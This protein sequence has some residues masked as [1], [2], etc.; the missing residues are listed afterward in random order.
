MLF[1]K[2]QLFEKEQNLT[3]NQHKKQ[4][5]N[6]KNLWIAY[7]CFFFNIYFLVQDREAVIYAASYFLW[8]GLTV[9]G[10][11]KDSLSSAFQIWI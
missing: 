9:N 3:I 5:T 1:S 8:M 7:F 6:L 4:A 10:L 2:G 11:S